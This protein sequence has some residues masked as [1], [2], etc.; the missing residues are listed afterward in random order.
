[1]GITYRP[2]AEEGWE[3]AFLRRL[4]LNSV[5][6]KDA[7]PIPRIDDT[8]DTLSGSKFFTTLDLASGY[9]QVPVDDDDK[10]KTAFAT[11]SGFHQF[12]VMPFGLCNAPSTFERLMDR[13]LRGL[14]WH[15]CLVYLDDIIVYSNSFD[16]HL[17]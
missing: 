3:G 12:E 1:M 9:W 11:P 2:S 17:K 4:P 15:V 5:T 16:E 14:Q 13:V 8:I 6:R 10:E 7:Y